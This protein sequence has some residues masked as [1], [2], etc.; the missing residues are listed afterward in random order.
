MACEDCRYD[1][2]FARADGQ[3]KHKLATMV[4]LSHG[5]KSWELCAKCWIEGTRKERL[6]NIKPSQLDPAPRRDGV[7]VR[8]KP[9][10]YGNYE[11]P[12]PT[13]AFTGET[14]TY[15][16]DSDNFW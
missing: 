1:P 9:D 11:L 6:G 15:I 7:T 5:G 4:Q 10:G 3:E 2:T 14:G 13:V 12:K 16:P 8:E